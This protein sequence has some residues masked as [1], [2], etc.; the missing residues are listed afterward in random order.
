MH[1]PFVLT[2]AVPSVVP[3]LFSGLIIVLTHWHCCC[4]CLKNIMAN[5]IYTVQ[6]RRKKSK[7]KGMEGCISLHD[8][9]L[10]EIKTMAA[11]LDFLLCRTRAEGHKN[12]NITNSAS[13]W[14]KW[15]QPN[16]WSTSAVRNSNYKLKWHCK[17]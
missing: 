5:T 4:C 8:S 1:R 17:Y 10:L 14:R 6:I 15:R 11:T 2:P 12:T 9:F 13:E 7:E 16:V 3:F